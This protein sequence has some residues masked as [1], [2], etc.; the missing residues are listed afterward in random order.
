MTLDEEEVALDMKRIASV[1]N[2]NVKEWKK[3]QTKKGRTRSGKFLIEG[4]HLVEEAMKSGVEIDEWI[5]QEG[6]IHPIEKEA[7]DRSLFVVTSGVMKEIAGTEHP[8][9]LV[10]VCRKFTPSSFTE[11]PAGKYLLIDGVQDPGNVGTIIR[12]ADAAGMTAVILGKGSVDPF[13]DKVLRASQGSLFHLPVIE[14]DLHEWITDLKNQGVPVFGTSVDGGKHYAEAEVQGNFALIVGNEGSG[15][16]PE[17]LESTD[18]N[19]CIPI[20]GKAESLNVSVAA[21]ILM[22][23]LQR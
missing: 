4:P 2:P 22:F 8:Q 16:D 17:L 14:G 13:N 11:T 10:C 15:V 7:D 3:L 20:R 18:E 19:L 6:V 23:G 9:G 12:T 1:Q 5:V 21:G